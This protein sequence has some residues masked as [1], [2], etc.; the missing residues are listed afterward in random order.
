MFEESE[1]LE[2][3]E[4]FLEDCKKKARDAHWY[5]LILEDGIGTR[6]PKTGEYPTIAEYRSRLEL[7]T[8]NIRRFV[9]RDTWSQYDLQWKK[10]K[11]PEDRDKLCETSPTIFARKRDLFEFMEEVFSNQRAVPFVNC[12]EIWKHLQQALSSSAPDVLAVAEEPQHPPQAD[13]APA[14][15][16][17]RPDTQPPSRLVALFDSGARSTR[18]SRHKWLRIAIA[19][20]ARARQWSS[21]FPIIAE[22]AAMVMGC[23][24]GAFW[25]VLGL[26]SPEWL[27]AIPGA[28]HVAARNG[29]KML[30]WALGS[31]LS[32]LAQ[33]DAQTVMS[34]SV[35]STLGARDSWYARTGAIR[36]I[37]TAHGWQ[38]PVGVTFLESL[39][40]CRS[41]VIRNA[42]L[43]LVAHAKSGPEQAVFALGWIIRWL[44]MIAEEDDR[45]A[46]SALEDSLGARLDGLIA[47]RPEVALDQIPNIMAVLP[48]GHTERYS[49]HKL[50]F[51]S[52]GP[53]E[54][55]IVQV[56]DLLVRELQEHESRAKALEILS[57]LLTADSTLARAVGMSAAAAKDVKIPADIILIALRDPATYVP[58]LRQWSDYLIGAIF[59]L[60]T[61]E[62]RAAVTDTLLSLPEDERDGVRWAVVKFVAL[63]AIPKKYAAQAIESALDGLQAANPHLQRSTEPPVRPEP[64]PDT[65][66]GSPFEP[67]VDFADLVADPTALIERIEELDALEDVDTW[68]RVSEP[69]SEAL[70]KAPDAIVG[71]AEAVAEAKPSR[72]EWIVE[73]IAR[74]V[75]ESPEMAADVVLRVAEVLKPVS[76]PDVHKDLSS[77]ISRKWKGMDREQEERALELLKAWS[78]PEQETDPSVESSEEW[79]RGE[80]TGDAV[81]IGLNTARGSVVV[82]LVDIAKLE[83]DEETGD[84]M[85]ENVLDILAK[86]ASD[87]AP[88][89]RAL[90]MAWLR[91]LMSRENKD[92]IVNTAML[93]LKDF[94]Y[95]VL[96]YASP[97]FRVLSADQVNEFGL[98][99]ARAML[100]VEGEAAEGAGFL[101][102]FWSLRFDTDEAKKLVDEIIA[103]DSVQ[104]KEAAARVFGYNLASKDEVVRQ[105]SKRRCLQ[106]L[107]MKQ[108]TDVRVAVANGI[109]FGEGAPASAEALEI[110]GRVAR[111]EESKV[112][113]TLHSAL[114]TNLEETDNPDVITMIAAVILGVLGNESDQ[115]REEFLHSNGYEVL[116]I[117]GLLKEAGYRQLALAL[118]DAACYH[119]VP[120]ANALLDEA[121]A[122]L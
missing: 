12:D 20:R 11:T 6:D 96:P 31:K 48:A 37:S 91:N 28:F 43:R 86:V 105:E 97:L 95:A 13:S 30:V 38:D 41:D 113:A 115:V 21:S 82:S 40:M 93:C 83:T 3:G 62:Q 36:V 50:V 67:A 39:D 109:P 33:C 35:V 98:N 60:F 19:A 79:M 114:P 64:E 112:V 117:Y 104:A 119:R 15:S 100:G 26:D 101:S 120:E 106:L 73:G 87:P 27:K 16:E 88:P 7:K 58:D 9:H 2:T 121:E 85:R 44:K 29:D 70:K 45:G 10:A 66:W 53:P 107:D 69:L 92:W 68:Y 47:E 74:A 108:P 77:A 78:D 25:F 71:V 118:L 116:E 94:H 63:D 5:V 18:C 1:W 72:T 81:D 111:D 57:D 122:D 8:A 61:A 84:D 22:S 23:G 4:G 14:P 54:P 51:G 89:V 46:A 17:L 59:P 52:P 34:S 55:V 110:V 32:E 24:R 103:S 76:T 102:S 56:R 90:L 99:T 80:G 42:A 75:K 65:E 49:V